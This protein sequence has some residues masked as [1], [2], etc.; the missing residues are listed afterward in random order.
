[1]CVCTRVPRNIIHTNK[2]KHTLANISEGYV[3]FTIL[4]FTFPKFEFF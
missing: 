2:L 4:F 3:M 1:M